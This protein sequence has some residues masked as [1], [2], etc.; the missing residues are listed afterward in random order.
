[1]LRSYINRERYLRNDAGS[2]KGEDGI[3]HP[4]I[5]EAWGQYQNIVLAPDVRE[6]DF[7]KTHKSAPI[8]TAMPVAGLRR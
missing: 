4:S 5:R 8:S 1:M 7:L 2:G 3:L 6:D